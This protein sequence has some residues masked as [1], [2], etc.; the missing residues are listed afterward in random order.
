MRIGVRIQVVPAILSGKVL[1]KGTAGSFRYSINSNFY[2]KT[3]QNFVKTHTNFALR[4]HRL[5]TH[6]SHVSAVIN[7]SEFKI[8]IDTHASVHIHKCY[9]QTPLHYTLKL[10]MSKRYK[11]LHACMNLRY[12][13][14]PYLKEIIM[15][16]G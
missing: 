1:V 9:S 16:Y 3:A 5:H 6:Y 10:S 2:N 13:Y 4:K 11:L 8:F 15:L 12:L 7:Y 14:I